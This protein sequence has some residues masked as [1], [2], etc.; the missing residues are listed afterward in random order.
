MEREER[1]HFYTDQSEAQNVETEG[2]RVRDEE[3]KHF[4]TDQSE[5]QK[6]RR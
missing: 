4:Y 2:E 6:G 5:P 1:K 3:R